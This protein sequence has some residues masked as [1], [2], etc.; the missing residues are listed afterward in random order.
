MI[1]TSALEFAFQNT[2]PQTLFGL[3]IMSV[4][5][6][7]GGYG[8]VGTMLFFRAHVGQSARPSKLK[9]IFFFVICIQMLV[10]TQLLL[11]CIWAF[12]LFLL[13]LVPDWFT[14]IR[15]SASCYT[16]LGNFPTTLPTGWHLAP[17]FIAFSG[18]FSFAWASASTISMLNA[19]N[20]YLDTSK[21]EMI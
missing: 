4:V 20:N 15:L 18:L 19:L 10:L 14:A 13:G 12:S 17:A 1:S 7:I 21:N 5:L 3:V 16:T 8:F 9:A 11:M 2:I 6:I